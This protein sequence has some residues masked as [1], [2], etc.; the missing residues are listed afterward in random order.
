MHHLPRRSRVFFARLLFLVK[1]IS[2]SCRRRRRGSAGSRTVSRPTR[3]LSAYD[4]PLYTFLSSA[5]PIIS[6]PTVRALP[7]ACTSL[8]ERSRERS[9]DRYRSAARTIFFL[10]APFLSFPRILYF[11]RS[12]TASALIIQLDDKPTGSLDKPRN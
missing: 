2:D 4:A 10:F 9:R 11:S 8:R 1:I 7:F 5:N 6:R 12:R 3:S